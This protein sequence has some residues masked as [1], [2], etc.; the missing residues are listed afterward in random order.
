MAGGDR[1]GGEGDSILNACNECAP[2]AVGPF[3]FLPDQ[4][5]FIEIVSMHPASPTFLRI[6]II[7]MA[8]HIQSKNEK[9]NHNTVRK[10][11]KMDKS[12]C[13]YVFNGYLICK[14]Y[15]A[16]STCRHRTN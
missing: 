1:D 10:F 7:T 3:E 2:P 9:E 13:R 15:S 4:N 11:G 12:A 14:W 6:N 8:L 5:D 16:E